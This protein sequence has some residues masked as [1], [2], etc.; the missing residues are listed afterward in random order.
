MK[1]K[2]I[3]VYFDYIPFIILIVSACT[4]IWTISTT[5]IL[6]AWKHYLGLILRPIVAFLFYK[7]HLLGVLSLGLTLIVGLIGFI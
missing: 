5:D 7:K 1:K 6:L 3:K 2:N 4:L